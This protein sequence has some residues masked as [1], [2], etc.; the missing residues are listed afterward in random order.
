MESAK[1]RAQGPIG[2]NAPI[3]IMHPDRLLPMQYPRLVTHHTRFVQSWLPVEN[4]DVS[5]AQMPI[6]L[7]VDCLCTREQSRATRGAMIAL[8]RCEELIRDGGTLLDAQLVLCQQYS[9][10]M[11]CH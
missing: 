7:L 11:Q 6:H 8:L 5:V 1:L 9:V 3:R 4:E 10:T 2:A